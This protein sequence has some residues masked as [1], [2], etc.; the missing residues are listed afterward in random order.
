MVMGSFDSEEQPDTRISEVHTYFA[1]RNPLED[2]DDPNNYRSVEKTADPNGGDYGSDNIKSIFSRWIPLGG[3]TT[4]Q[5]LN[6]LQLGRFV[7]PPRRFEFELARGNSNSVMLGQGY[8]LSAANM[9]SVT[10][11]LAAAPIQVVRLTPGADLIKVEAEEANFTFFD[12]TSL[13]DR[14]II[15]DVNTLNFNLR[16]AHDSLFPAPVDADV[17]YVTVTCVINPGVVVGAS[18]TSNRA[19]DVGS[20]P[21]GLDVVVRVLGRIQGR[22]GDGGPGSLFLFGPGLPGGPA[23]YTRF[24]I[25]LEVDAGEIWSGGG[26]GA[27]LAGGG[28]G[29]A[30]SLPGIGGHELR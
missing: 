18:L 16:S 21:S 11:E 5:R 7:A 30:G 29:G 28:G 22:G 1:Q 26:G 20:W 4:A 19:F 2:Q 10:G 9:Q 23:L 12:P 13:T 15:V 24:P 17:G 27:G 3:R 25:D 14:V 6:N 8:Q